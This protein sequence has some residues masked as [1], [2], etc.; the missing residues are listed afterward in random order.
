VDA[1]A[2]FEAMLADA[3]PEA[4]W[5]STVEARLARL[6]PPADGQAAVIAGL[7]PAARGEAIRSMVEGLAARLGQQGG[8][9]EEWAKLV[10]SYAVLGE[11]DKARAA[12]ASARAALPD[13]ASRATLSQVARASGLETGP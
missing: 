1:I 11:T 4:P 7:P 9:A 6:K 8:S 10:R 2:A 13:E 3:P 5:R 12:L